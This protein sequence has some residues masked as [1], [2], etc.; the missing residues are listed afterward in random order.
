MDNLT[1]I[2][3]TSTLV[4]SAP[5]ATVRAPEIEPG[6]GCNFDSYLLVPDD[7]LND[8]IAAAKARLGE[9]V[10]ILGTVPDAEMPGWY[11]AADTFV[12]PSV[13]EGFG[14]VVLEAMAAGLPVVVSDIPVFRE[15]L[16]RGEALLSRAGDSAS[17]ARAM[18]RAVTDRALAVREQ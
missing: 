14:L 2:S 8:R 4:G 9:D 5:P 16:D 6:V 15:F 17:L 11:Q 12:F 7:T 1:S 18:R 13:K 3:E 10:V